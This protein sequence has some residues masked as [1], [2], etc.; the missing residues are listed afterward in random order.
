MATVSHAMARP[1]SVSASGAAVATG[2]PVGLVV[3]L[4]RPEFRD[5]GDGAVSRE[6]HPADAAVALM[7]ETLDAERFGPTALRLARLATS[8]RCFE[9]NVGTPAA[10]ADHIEA[11]FRLDR[12]TPLDVELRTPSPVIPAHVVSV[13]VGDRTVVHDQRSGRIFAL[14]AA[15]TRIWEHLGGWRPDPSIDLAGPGV[16]PFVAQLRALGVLSEPATNGDRA[17]ANETR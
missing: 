6:L 9:L 17:R 10:T 16:A 1:P 15:A 2:G 7:Q 4:R 8:C 3:L 14:D 5:P 11:L 12:P 13:V